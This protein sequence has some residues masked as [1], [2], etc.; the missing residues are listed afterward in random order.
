M[1]FINY[2]DQNPSLASLKNHIL[3]APHE[4]R[5]SAA[6]LKQYLTEQ[7]HM[8][9]QIADLPAVHDDNPDNRMK[10]L[11]TH[12]E[13]AAINRQKHEALPDERRFVAFKNQEVTNW[14]QARQFLEQNGEKKL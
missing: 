2:D 13:S 12:L 4:H 10:L 5:S 1:L 3:T 8:T 14:H 11:M 9:Q 7:H 6:Q